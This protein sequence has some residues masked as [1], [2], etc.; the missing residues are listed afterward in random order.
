MLSNSDI[1]N[2]AFYFSH[3]DRRLT[4]E[5]GVSD[6]PDERELTRRL[7]RM[8]A[9]DEMW[10]IDK[11]TI[12]QDWLEDALGWS[13]QL[14][15]QAHPTKWEHHVSHSDF[16]LI[17]SFVDEL[18]RTPTQS[19][20]Y[21]VQAKRL[22][23]DVSGQY[24]LS[25]EFGATDRDQHLK[26]RYLAKRFGEAA[27]KFAAYCPPIEFFEFNSVEAIQ[28]GHKSN[29]SALY[30]GSTFGLALQQQI[31]AEPCL[32]SDAGFW[33][34]P[35]HGQFKTAGDLH[36]NA[37]LSNLPFG[38]FVIAN[39]WNLAI[40]GSAGLSLPAA[41]YVI[42]WMWNNPTFGSILNLGL[43]AETQR[44]ITGLARGD[45]SIA[46]ELAA[47]TDAKVPS[48][49]FKP[50]VTFEITLTRHVHPLLKPT[51]DEKPKDEP[52]NGLIRK[53]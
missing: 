35:T 27:V 7:G 41:P 48:S 10:K 42:P 51:L 31:E 32:V 2:L 39:A 17:I 19:A 14:T 13:L 36:R 37:I 29:S 22:Y 50:S 11:L 38:W 26:L 3:F 46:H 9:G 40:S 45:D 18:L 16:G 47:G 24:S 12:A 44:L 23:P 1:L 33:I 53:I 8:L 15:M 21:L 43:D 25:S 49:A 28:I 4:S 5:L 30:V 6:P 20:A 52:D 34:A